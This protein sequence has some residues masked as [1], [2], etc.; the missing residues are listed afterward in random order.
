MARY[1]LITRDCKVCGPEVLQAARTPPNHLLHLLLSIPTM[2]LW[3]IVWFFV[4]ISY[5][6]DYRC[7]RCSGFI[8][9]PDAVRN[10]LVDL[11]NK[12]HRLSVRAASFEPPASVVRETI[13]PVAAP[14]VPPLAAEPAITSEIPSPSFPEVFWPPEAPM[15]A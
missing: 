3:L 12:I 11:E 13:Q 14:E 4:T 8:P 5:R 9:V 15:I 7:L 2:G 1:S 6:P 10:R